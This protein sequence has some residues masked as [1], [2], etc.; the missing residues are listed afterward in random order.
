MDTKELEEIFGEE[1]TGEVE[2]KPLSLEDAISILES[3][4]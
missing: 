2:V 3:N 1:T 4:K